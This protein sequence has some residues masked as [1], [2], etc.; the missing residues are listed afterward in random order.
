MKEV[1][2]SELE[3]DAQRIMIICIGVMAKMYGH[4]GFCLTAYDNKDCDECPGQVDCLELFQKGV[5]AD[6]EK[7]EEAQKVKEEAEEF[8]ARVIAATKTLYSLDEKCYLCDDRAECVF[9]IMSKTHTFDSFRED[10]SISQSAEKDEYIGHCGTRYVY[11]KCDDC[12]DRNNCLASYLK[13]D[14]KNDTQAS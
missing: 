4:A 6:A 14:T 13:E 5:E 1:K 9:R 7:A 3:G 11:E 10:G 12:F 2:L 8:T